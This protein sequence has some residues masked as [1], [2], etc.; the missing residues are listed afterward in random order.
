MGT[1]PFVFCSIFIFFK[2][3]S[4]EF[5]GSVEKILIYYSVIIS[6]FISGSHWGQG[7]SLNEKFNIFL[8]I[9]TNL[10][11]IILFL[12]LLVFPFNTLIS[13]LIIIFLSFIIVDIKLEKIGYISGIYLKD[14]FFVTLIVVASL[15]VSIC[16]KI[17][18]I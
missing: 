10:I 7:I 3:E 4:L 16:S 8:K 15:L 13:T 9:Y 2:V 17:L 18:N 11:A 5:F 1:I 6:S 14:R 12:G